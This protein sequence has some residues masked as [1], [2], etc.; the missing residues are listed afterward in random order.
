MVGSAEGDGDLRLGAIARVSD[1]IFCADGKHPAGGEFSISS[2]LSG[3]KAPEDSGNHFVMIL[4]GVIVVP[5]WSV[6]SGSIVVVVVRLFGLEL[7]SQAE[8]VLHLVLAVLMEGHGPSRIFL[9]Y[10]L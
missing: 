10:S 8:A 2:T 5:R 4:E 7:P 3:S 6:A 1:S 9:Y